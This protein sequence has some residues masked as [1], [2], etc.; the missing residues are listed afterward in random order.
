MKALKFLKYKGKFYQPGS[1][2]AVDKDDVE[3][4]IAKGLIFAPEVEEAEAAEVD[5]T[6]AEIK[7]LLDEE[8][9]DYNPKA[10]KDELLA[11]LEG[12]DIE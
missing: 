12:E 7:A 6:K 2:I 5:L 4:F 11:L 10:N 3:G 1:N 9:I 8:G